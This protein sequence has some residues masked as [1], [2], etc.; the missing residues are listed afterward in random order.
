M[1]AKILCLYY[2]FAAAAGLSGLELVSGTS[3]S[4]RL[5]R[6]VGWLV[7]GVR[8]IGRSVNRRH[9]N[10]NGIRGIAPYSH[11]QRQE[12]PVGNLTCFFEGVTPVC[13]NATDPAAAAATATFT[14]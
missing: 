9:D 3:A 2:L 14:S 13:V 8:G 6:P 12:D 11:I 4:W 10:P 5:I 1:A 7:D